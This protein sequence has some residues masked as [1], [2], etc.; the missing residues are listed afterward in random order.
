[1][2]LESKSFADG[3][4]IPGEFAFAVI[5]PTNHISLSNNRNP[6]LKWSGVPKATQSFALI[7]RDNDVTN[8]RSDVNQEDREIPASLPRVA[9]SSI[10]F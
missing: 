6:H 7:C 3:A 4:A 1:M 5:S 2:Q 8:S 9:L 10:G